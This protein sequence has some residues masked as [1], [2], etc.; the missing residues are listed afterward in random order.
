[1]DLQSGG[2]GAQLALG[3]YVRR[4][5]RCEDL[6]RP[7]V[8]LAVSLDPP[9][10]LTAVATAESAAAVPAAHMRA[11]T[12]EPLTF[13][14]VDLVSPHV[15]VQ[16]ARALDFAPVFQPLLRRLMIAYADP[17]P[18]HSVSLVVSREPPSPRQA[19]GGGR[20]R[21]PGDSAR[22]L[23]AGVGARGVRGRISVTRLGCD[24]PSCEPLNELAT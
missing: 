3:N 20:A 23:Q 6:T 22:A 16:A 18:N 8:S 13:R 9:R 11:G 14:V 2:D 24:A 12:A 5:P 10:L 15:S 7:R 21:P 1:M 4:T 17:T 19:Q